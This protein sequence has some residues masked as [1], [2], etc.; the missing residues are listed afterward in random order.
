MPLRHDHDCI[1]QN[2][3]KDCELTDS[4]DT[5]SNI[6]LRPSS[7][8]KESVRPGCRMVNVITSVNKKRTHHA[9]QYYERSLQPLIKPTSMMDV[10]ER[11]KPDGNETFYMT[12]WNIQ[13]MDNTVFRVKCIGIF[14]LINDAK[15]K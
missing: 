13:D 6:Y 15:L 7:L 3:D 5:D 11:D 1:K 8:G 2:D 14:M 10:T 9:D 4:N 12:Y